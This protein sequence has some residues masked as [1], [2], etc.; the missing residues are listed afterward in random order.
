M[1]RLTK[2]P[3]IELHFQRIWFV[4]GWAAD[5]ETLASLY[6]SVDVIDWCRDD[7]ILFDDSLNDNVSKA[8]ISALYQRRGVEPELT[9]LHRYVIDR[10]SALNLQLK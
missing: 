9:P 8:A 10:Q 7:L 1:N 6:A 5:G 2:N 4:Y 3:I